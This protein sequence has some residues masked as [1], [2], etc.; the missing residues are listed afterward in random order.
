VQGHGR[1]T[2]AAER[3]KQ[4]AIQSGIGGSAL[5]YDGA[6]TL[7]ERPKLTDSNSK[8]LAVRLRAM[9]QPGESAGC[10]S[11]GLRRNRRCINSAGIDP[12]VI[13]IP[14]NALVGGW[15]VSLFAGH[16]MRSAPAGRG[17]KSSVARAHPPISSKAG[18]C[19]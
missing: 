4:V 10:I 15:G 11:S 7:L 13:D 12:A 8:A 16:L 2:V 9:R 6:I 18:G 5:E 19:I 3:A 17:R 1:E 14:A